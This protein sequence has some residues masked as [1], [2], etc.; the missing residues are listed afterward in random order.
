MAENERL[1]LSMPLVDPDGY[2]EAAAAYRAT[3]EFDEAHRNLGCTRLLTWIQREPA[4][5]IIRWEGVNVLESVARTASTTD[6]FFARWRELV[7]LFAGETGEGA[8]WH[9]SH[10]RVFSWTS[11]EEGPEASVRVF[12]G[13]AAITDYLWTM[14]DVTSVPG[15]LGVFDRIRR[16]QGFTRLE[17]WHQSLGE[18][19]VVLWL[20]EGRQLEAAY[21][22]IFEGKN[23]FD[24]RVRTLVKASLD[25]ND[26]SGGMPELVV[27]WVA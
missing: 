11:G 18:D 1:L 3:P 23:D 2:K 15:L 8:L 9:A 27:D 24:R 25:V 26:P 16:Q 20:A 14:E 13:T 21:A 6:P 4:Y 19:D 10:H 22:N 12:H 5:A 17:V 7:R